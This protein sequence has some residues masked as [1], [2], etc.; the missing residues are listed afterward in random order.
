LSYPFAWFEKA[1]GTLNPRLVSHRPWVWPEKVHADLLP[2]G[3]GDVY[4][5]HT[6]HIPAETMRLLAAAGLETLNWSTFEFPPPQ[7]R[8][9]RKL[10]RIGAVGRAT[11]DA[12]EFV[13]RR[14]PLL[15]RL[16]THLFVVAA[17]QTA[18]VA[19]TP[20]DGV[21]SGPLSGGDGELRRLGLS[22]QKASR[23]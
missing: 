16:G 13:A 9:A 5:P 17:K 20:P 23:A 15:R 12:I 1:L 11:A 22:V 7:S 6:H 19:P 14:V 3:V 18:P 2:A 10:M 4:L 21:W 8:T